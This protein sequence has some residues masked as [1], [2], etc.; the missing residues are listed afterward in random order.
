MRGFVYKIESDCKQIVYIG[1]TTRK[2]KYRFSGHKRKTNGYSVISKYL[3]DSNYSFSN[4]CELIKEY[5]IADRQH[6]LAYEQL[7]MNVY[8]K[9]II[10]QRQSYALLENEQKKQYY[11]SNKEKYVERAKQYYE[12]NKEKINER[13]KQKVICECDSIIRI[14]DLKRHQQTAKH[15]ILLESK[16]QLIE[17]LSFA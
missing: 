13:R 15:Q 12:A 5:E 16:E 6:L 11:E 9:K 2:L 1:S 14:N 7:W 3:K 10:N 4:G 8:R 17:C